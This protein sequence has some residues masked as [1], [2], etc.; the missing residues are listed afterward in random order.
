MVVLRTVG[1]EYQGT[2]PPLQEWKPQIWQEIFDYWQSC[3]DF[4][5]VLVEKDN[6]ISDEAKNIIGHSIRG[7]MQNGRIEMLDNAIKQSHYLKR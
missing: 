6:Q 1:A 3:F 4:L 5:I 2:K 7:L